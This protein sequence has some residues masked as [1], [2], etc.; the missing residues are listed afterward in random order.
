MP[1]VCINIVRSRKESSRHALKPDTLPDSIEIL[2]E[3]Y[4]KRKSISCCVA[5]VIIRLL[6]EF[7]SLS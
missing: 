3:S 1:T 2:H 5:T 4:C 7:L 6:S